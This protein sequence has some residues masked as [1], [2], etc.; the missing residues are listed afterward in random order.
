MGGT[1]FAP[2]GDHYLNSID[3]NKIKNIVIKNGVTRIGNSMFVG[4]DNLTSIIIPSS[5]TSIGS[6]A[7]ADCNRLVNI[8]I[9]KDVINIG[10]RAFCRCT[11]LTNITIPDGLTSIEW[12]TFSSC[13]CLASIEIPNGVTSIERQAFYGCSN[14]T[15]VVVPDSV[16]AIGLA[17][18]YGTGLKEIT[19][20]FIGSELNSPQN[21]FFGMIFAQELSYDGSV[22]PSTYYN[23]YKQIPSTLKKVTITGGARIDENA[24]YKC[25]TI[26]EIIIEDGVRAIS[27]DAFAYCTNLRSITIP[28]SVKEIGYNAFFHCDLL[29][30]KGYRNSQADTFARHNDIPIE[31]LD[32]GPC[33]HSFGGWETT[34]KATCTTAGTQERTCSICGQKE[35]HSILATG[36]SFSG[37][38][39]T[40]EATCTFGGTE[41]RNCL[42]CGQ[43]E[44]RTTNPLGHSFA[45][46][47]V[48]K[49]PAC[50]D[51]G[52][53]SGTCIRC[54]Q[55]TTQAIPATGH[56]FGSW[57]QTK[58][59]TCTEKGIEERVC[60]A[61]LQT[62]T[63]ETQ[64]LGHDFENPVIVKEATISTTGL[65]EGKC[66]RCGENTQEIIPCRAEDPVTGISVE[67]EQGVFSEGTITEFSEIGESD[68]SFE[69]LKN[70]LTDYGNR[71]K[72]YRIDFSNAPNGKY[73]LI[74]PNAIKLVAD[75]AAVYLVADDGNVTEKE[76][77]IDSDGNFVVSTDVAGIYAVLDKNSSASSE[78]ANGDATLSTT[79]KNS[80]GIWIM[81]AILVAMIAIAGAAIAVIYRKK[82]RNF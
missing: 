68:A 1:D 9:P 76:F 31:Y 6:H 22:V 59:A 62:E 75:S 73:I 10:A 65:M 55:T 53:E 3:R 77:T 56:I 44:S 34:Q 30:I 28:E 74:L 13:S 35:T 72:A 12:G 60:S 48:T 64:V 23:A 67:A 41:T 25:S 66:K 69:S 57:Q 5:V 24:F 81:I 82:K 17:A 14:L 4:L 50:T 32:E 71:F 63:R 79:D 27:P 18:F 19:L 49:Q 15:S 80:I 11:S 33:N 43:S 7:F 54:G 21:T 78:L 38:K 16:T 8:N 61:C 2:S 37:W 52:I 20:P 40:K 70:A 29:T 51:T 58:A 26:E 47:T 39:V 45:S 36:H 42:K 46:T